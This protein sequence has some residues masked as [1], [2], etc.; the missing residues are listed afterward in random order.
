MKVSRFQPPGVHLN[1]LLDVAMLALRATRLHSAGGP[2]SPGSPLSFQCF[3][4]S[5][6]LNVPSACTPSIHE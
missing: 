6:F 3:S 2:I 1:T 5:A 4:V